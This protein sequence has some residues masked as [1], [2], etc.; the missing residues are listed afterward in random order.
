MHRRPLLPALAAAALP[1]PARAEELPRGP[2]RIVSGF[3]P[4]GSIDTL[5]RFLARLAGER[6]GRTFVVENRPGAAGIVGTA[7]VARSAPTGETLLIGELGT[8]VTAR[9]IFRDLPYDPEADFVPVIL[10]A[11][12]PIVLATATGATSLPDLIARAR[13]APGRVTHGAPGLGTL[14]QLLGAELS[15]LAGVELTDVYYRSGGEGATA[16]LKGE[17]DLSFF[18]LATALPHL[19]SGAARALA[20]LEPA[21]LPGFPDIPAAAET[22]PGLA[23]NFWYG[24]HAPA[25]TPPATVAAVNAALAAGLRDPE[26][27]R[28]LSA[29]G[30]QP[31]GGTAAEYGALLARERAT[32]LPVVRRLGLEGTGGR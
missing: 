25:A 14:P 4:G 12:Q 30:F 10:G 27:T 26:A 18:A 17:V 1:R 31:G 8:V 23:A 13:A 15:R 29:A 2:F 32:W 19:R 7:A 3:A 6:T 16:L 5:A 9:A 22:L 24:L 20:V 21:R 28:A 11:T